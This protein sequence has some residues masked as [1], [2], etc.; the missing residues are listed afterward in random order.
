TFVKPW[1]E[2]KDVF[3]G[4]KNEVWEAAYRTQD[5]LMTWPFKDKESSYSNFQKL[6][7][8]GHFGDPIS[9]DDLLAY[10]E[11]L[12]KTQFPARAEHLYLFLAPDGGDD[13]LPVTFDRKLFNPYPWEKDKVPTVEEAWLAQEEIWLRREVFHLL[14]TSLQA[15]AKFKEEKELRW[16]D[17]LA[18]VAGVPVDGLVKNSPELTRDT[19]RPRLIPEDLVKK[20]VKESRLF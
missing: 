4:R 7:Q 11:K 2:R 14:Q 15:M 3:T 13:Y 17:S 18:A 19:A 9:N 16:K 5:G 8:A 1:D 12:Y 20:G 10:K 6:G